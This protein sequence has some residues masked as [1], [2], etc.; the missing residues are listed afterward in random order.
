MYTVDVVESE[1]DLLAVRKEWKKLLHEAPEHEFHQTP[2]NIHLLLKHIY[3]DTRIRIFLI[4]K[5]GVLQSIAP[6]SLM[7][8][9]FKLSLGIIRLWK[10]HIR[11]YKLYGTCLIFSGQADQEKCL[12][13]LAGEL[14]TRKEE[15]DLVYLESL[16][17][18]SPLYR[19]KD[20]LPGYKIYPF[21]AKKNMVQG[22]RTSNSF[23][24]Y[25]STFRKK[26]R[27]N[28]KRN[29]R[30]LSDAVK[31]DYQMEKIC[32]PEQ[33]ESFMTAVDYIY[34]RCWQ[35]KTYGPHKHGTPG[36]IAY[37]QSL[38]RL[39][40]LRCY[41]LTCSGKPAAY[42]IGYQYERRYYYEYIGYDQKWSHLSPGTVL[43]Y[44]MIEELHSV[45]RPEILDFGYGENT[46][47]KIFGN[48]SYEA[49][50]TAVARKYSRMH[51]TMLTQ[52]F[53]SRLYIF[54]SGLLIKTGLD[55]KIRKSLK[56]Q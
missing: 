51:F 47:K 55:K 29:I 40:W 50:N 48:Y 17:R 33:V 30:V 45:D 15:H 31:G 14:S 39:G 53:L 5:N 1:S 8:G 42:I 46:Y 32:R 7:Q 26:K 18:N 11:Q 20:P 36:N 27:Y 54:V 13:A 52:L 12:H 28:L 2:D 4:R 37:H 24:E 38:S 43:T 25:L 3:T 6:F 23:Q 9:K 19:L 34:E 10:F 22:L 21:S 16:A 41:L 56:R 49:D 44:L 35:R